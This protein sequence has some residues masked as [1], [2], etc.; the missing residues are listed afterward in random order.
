MTVN[1][2]LT[3]VALAIA[4]IAS[5]SSALAAQTAIKAGRVIDPSGRAI[6]NAVI[7]VEN[8]RIVSIGTSV[9]PGADVID[10]GRYTIVPGM[11]DV[12]THMTYYWDGAPGTRPRGVNR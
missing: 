11:I 3:P 12:H 5:S 8:D 4:V 1:R 9:P 6:A 7:I 10:L 2:R